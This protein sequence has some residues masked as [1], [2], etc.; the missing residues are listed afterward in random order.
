MTKCKVIVKLSG[1]FS[2]SLGLSVKLHPSQK[3]I[4]KPSW[5]SS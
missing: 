2:A 5:F 1:S 3:R 4:D